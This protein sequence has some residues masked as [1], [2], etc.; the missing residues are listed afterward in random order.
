MV[1][2][3]DFFFSKLTDKQKTAMEEFQ[4]DEEVLKEHKSLWSKIKD[5]MKY[6][7]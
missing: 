1:T 2:R 7:A 4:K 6:S 5:Y 3:V